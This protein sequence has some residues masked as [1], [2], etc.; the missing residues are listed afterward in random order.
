MSF[1]ELSSVLGNVGEFVASIAVLVTLI[2]L[3]VQTRQINLQSQAEARY[4]FVD[5]MAEINMVIAHDKATA[6]VWRRGMA[7]IDALD[8]D[9]RMQFFMLVGQYANAWAV[10]YQLRRDGMLPEAQWLIVRN[11]IVSILSSAGGDAFW[12]QGGRAAFDREFV[13][14]VDTELGKGERPYDMVGMIT[15]REGSPS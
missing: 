9:E 12:H 8:E 15:G 6:S 3:A 14:Y 2:Y 1:V 13:D 5:A 7:S 10:M 4:A 11:D